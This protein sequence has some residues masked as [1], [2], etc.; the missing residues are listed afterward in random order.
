MKSLRYTVQAPSLHKGEITQDS[1]G[2][3]PQ[4]IIS[5][6]EMLPVSTNL[7]NFFSLLWKTYIRVVEYVE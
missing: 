5:E 7:F 2:V 3:F 4:F 6:T 1:A